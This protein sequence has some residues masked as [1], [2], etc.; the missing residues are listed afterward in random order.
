MDGNIKILS[1]QQ[2][3]LP[4]RSKHSKLYLVK[5]SSCNI[6]RFKILTVI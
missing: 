6:K 1:G 5:E 4:F 3:E 2:K